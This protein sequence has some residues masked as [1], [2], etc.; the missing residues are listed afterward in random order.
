MV[1]Y[2]Y[3]GYE[4]M[5]DAALLATPIT[6]LL[7]YLNSALNPLLY[8]FMSHNFRACVRDVLTCRYDIR[9]K[10]RRKESIQHIRLNTVRRQT[11]KVAGGESTTRV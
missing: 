7:T 8:S 5:S 2:Y 9:G 11:Y 1:S 4:A 3:E 6:N 10:R